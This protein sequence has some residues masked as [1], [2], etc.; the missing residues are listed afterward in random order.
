[1]STLDAPLSVGR[2]WPCDL[3]VVSWS[4]DLEWCKPGRRAGP[5]RP[6]SLPL[7]HPG[8]RLP[9]DVW[10]K[11]IAEAWRIQP[12]IPLSESLPLSTSLCMSLDVMMSVWRIHFLIIGQKF[13]RTMCGIFWLDFQET[14]VRRTWYPSWR[15]CCLELTSWN[16]TGQPGFVYMVC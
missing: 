10:Q 9:S 7:P 11:R 8:R 15:T 14:R 5:A 3:V 1:M 4:T 2:A 13:A 6:R 16:S 12:L